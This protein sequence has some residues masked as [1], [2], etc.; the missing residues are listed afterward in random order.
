M[1]TFVIAAVFPSLS[2]GCCRCSTAGC[3]DDDDDVGILLILFV[4]AVV[5]VVMV[6]DLVGA[7]V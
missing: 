6:V 7:V 3:R 5:V 2:E 1:V 4:V